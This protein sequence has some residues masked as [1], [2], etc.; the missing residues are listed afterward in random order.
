MINAIGVIYDIIIFLSILSGQW[1][2]AR[3]NSRNPS[4]MI[5][6]SL[7]SFW[8]GSLHRLELQVLEALG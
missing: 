7:R 6:A 5:S 8:R 4:L 3:L 2:M 1:N